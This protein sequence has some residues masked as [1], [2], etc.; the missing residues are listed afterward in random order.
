M[1]RSPHEAEAGLQNTSLSLLP[2]PR[3]IPMRVLLLRAAYSWMFD[4]TRVF[5]RELY[6]VSYASM[7]E[8]SARYNI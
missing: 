4:P 8:R 5:W 7:S 3:Q 1:D 2:W 6:V